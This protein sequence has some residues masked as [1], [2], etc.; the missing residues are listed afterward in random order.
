MKSSRDI[1]KT[2]SSDPW[3]MSSN[4]NS[5]VH[6]GDASDQ[7]PVQENRPHGLRRRTSLWK[8]DKFINLL[9]HQKR[10]RECRVLLRRHSDISQEPLLH[11]YHQLQQWSEIR[12]SE[13]IR[14]YSHPRGRDAFGQG[15]RVVLTKSFA[16][17]AMSMI[18]KLVRNFKKSI[19]PNKS[20]EGNGSRK[21]VKLSFSYQVGWYVHLIPWTSFTSSTEYA[22]CVWRPTE[23]KTGSSCG[24]VSPPH[25]APIKKLQVLNTRP[26]LHSIKRDESFTTIVQERILRAS[27]TFRVASERSS[28]QRGQEKRRKPRALSFYPATRSRVSLR[29]PPTRDFS[30]LP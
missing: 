3:A 30:Q 8:I 2:P 19:Q 29:V 15:L 24:C 17:L 20:W 18:Y 23:A 11:N 13:T 4:L 6:R 9:L 21:T 25:D 22:W 28:E 7:S 12:S 16:T 27:S 10:F 1:Q 5:G 14:H 26:H